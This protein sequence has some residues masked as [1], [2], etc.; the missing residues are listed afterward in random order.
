MLPL[1]LLLRP[2]FPHSNQHCPHS[3]GLAKQDRG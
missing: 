3:V 2:S 1:F